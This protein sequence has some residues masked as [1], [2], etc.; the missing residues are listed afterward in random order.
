MAQNDSGAKVALI[1]GANQGIGYA[2]AERLARDGMTVVVN[3]QRGDAVAK[4]AAALTEAGAIAI[5]LAADVSDEHAV[6]RM[7]D[8][9]RARFGRIDVV[10]N[11]AGVSPRIAG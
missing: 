10:V 3:G 4:A 8:D 9:I 2:V 6:S 5:G 1:T 11:N 7:F